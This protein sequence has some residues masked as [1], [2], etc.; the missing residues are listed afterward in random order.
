MSVRCKMRLN[1]VV[2]QTYGGVQAI[3]NCEYDSKIC[4]EDAGF[5]T[6]TP[7]GNDPAAG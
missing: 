3:F 1:A 7:L 6:A 5:E 4:E 2:G